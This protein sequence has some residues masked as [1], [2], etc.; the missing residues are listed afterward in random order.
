MLGGT[1][2]L[3][4]SATPSPPRLLPPSPP[5][6]SAARLYWNLYSGQERMLGEEPKPSPAWIPFL[7][8][9]LSFPPPPALP[10]N[11]GFLNWNPDGVAGGLAQPFSDRGCTWRLQAGL[12][13]VL[14]YGWGR[15]LLLVPSF[16]RTDGVTPEDR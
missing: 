11:S 6:G 12:D 4:P 5:F 15:N 7:A 16:N 3:S 14:K 2:M 13:E 1:G 9:T 10:P 8:A